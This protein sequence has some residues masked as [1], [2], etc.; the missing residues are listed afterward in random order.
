MSLLSISN[1][2]SLSSLLL[3]HFNP[4]DRKYVRTFFLTQSYIYHSS[5]LIYDITDNSRLVLLQTSALGNSNFTQFLRLVLYFTNFDMTWRTGV[6]QA[7][8][9]FYLRE[10]IFINSESHKSPIVM[11]AKKKTSLTKI[12]LCLLCKGT[13]FGSLFEEVFAL[14]LKTADVWNYKAYKVK[15]AIDIVRKPK[16]W[17]LNT[18]VRL[19]NSVFRSSSKK[20]VPPQ[21]FLFKVLNF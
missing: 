7:M 3:E 2:H 8:Y 4:I 21:I 16:N 6:P 5:S 19:P 12:Y 20:G 15:V 13:F 1:V 14:L 10:I 18:L 9:E 11:Y 17:S